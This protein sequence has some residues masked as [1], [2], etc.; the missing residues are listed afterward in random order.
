M[1]NTVPTTHK[2]CEADLILVPW[3]LNYCPKSPKRSRTLL[4]WTVWRS[5]EHPGCKEDPRI[6]LKLQRDRHGISRWVSGVTSG[7]ETVGGLSFVGKVLLIVSLSLISHLKDVSVALIAS[8]RKDGKWV[9]IHPSL[10]RIMD[11]SLRYGLRVGLL[12]L[13]ICALK[14]ARRMDLKRIS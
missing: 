8:F 14:R 4:P 2:V 10:L 11:G 1:P 3:C 9:W 5:Q 6:Y 12:L 7:R 13:A